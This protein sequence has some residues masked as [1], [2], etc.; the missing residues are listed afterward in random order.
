MN[1]TFDELAQAGFTTS[2]EA[3]EITTAFAGER[4]SLR[5]RNFA[6]RLAIGRS[7]SVREIPPPVSDSG[8][9][10]IRGQNLFGGGADLR[11]WVSLVI[12]QAELED[13][14]VEQIQDL[15][16]RHWARGALLLDREWSQCGED[17]DRFVLRLGALAGLPQTGQS[18]DPDVS[19]DP[20]PYEP[21]S[22]PIRLS[23]GPV[24]TDTNTGE[25]VHFPLNA[26][27]MSPHVALLGSLGTGKS[28]AAIHMLRELHAQSDGCPILVFDMK[29]DLCRS[30]ELVNGISAKVLAPPSQP[31]PL[32]VL[33][34]ADNRE[35]MLLDA[36]LRFRES[37]ARIPEGGRLGE[38]QK[39]SVG[40]AVRLAL[41][42][43]KPVKL[44]NVHA[45][46]KEIYAA[47]KRKEDT[48]LS[49]FNDISRLKLFTPELSPDAFFSRSW[50]LNLSTISKTARRLVAFLVLDAAYAFLKRKGDTGLDA[51]GN[52]A[53]RL[54]L[55]V[56][57]AREVLAYEQESLIGL[58]RESRSQ[59]GAVFMATQTPG[60]FSARNENF[61]DNIG[62]GLCLK[63][64]ANPRELK[65]LLGEDVDLASLGTGMAVARVGSEL[66]NVTLWSVTH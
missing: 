27:G 51:G 37:F 45:R 60:D 65:H 13:S 55:F 1:F 32:D 36:E 64:N 52:R 40:D 46:M 47:N 20:A 23:L 21:S 18:K 11:T 44:E 25:T 34:T 61:L 17:H 57:E 19:H 41:K 31:I 53:L 39:A 38:V 14:T 30:Q 28:R 10:V 58:V 3:D 8:G 66:K 16:R 59:G 29:G 5:G 7:L 48:A 63:T 43:Q 15:V 4:L 22:R 9:K 6:A 56:D 42:G 24:S 54:A 35:E 62:L 12:E 33:Y 26:Q 49:T 2:S 50:V